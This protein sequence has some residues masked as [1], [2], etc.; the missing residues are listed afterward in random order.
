MELSVGEDPRHG[1]GFTNFGQG[2]GRE[3]PAVDYQRCVTRPGTLFRKG[4]THR[5]PRRRS[6]RVEGDTDRMRFSAQNSPPFRWTQ[7][8]STDEDPCTVNLSW[9]A[10]GLNRP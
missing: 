1:E 9:T 2:K 6:E 3:P 8:S 4:D 5:R 10:F 7:G